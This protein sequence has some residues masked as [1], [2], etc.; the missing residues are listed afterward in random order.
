[1]NQPVLLLVT[2]TLNLLFYSVSAGIPQQHINFAANDDDQ[3]RGNAF[4][5]IPSSPGYGSVP[6]STGSLAPVQSVTRECYACTDCTQILPNTTV[7]QC[8]YNAARCVVYSEKYNH[9]SYPIYIRGCTSE[10]GTCYDVKK[11]HEG[12]QNVV[13][14]LS[15]EEC[16]GDKCNTNGAPKSLPDLTTAF[17]FI[18][19]CPVITK[20]TLT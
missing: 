20:Y 9:L 3:S 1:M 8:A 19:V 4:A 15:C 7:R 16:S 10:R 17:F 2:L 13:Q 6:V 5:S 11:S 12:H 14:L 18:I